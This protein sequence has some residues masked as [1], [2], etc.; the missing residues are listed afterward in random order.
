MTNAF[1]IIIILFCL[2]L[3]ACYP[4]SPFA[5]CYV[6]PFNKNEQKIIDSLNKLH[7]YGN[8]CNIS[9]IHLINI[10]NN[11]TCEISE[12]IY[13]L[14]YYITDSILFQ[15]T[16][17]LNT[18]SENLIKNIYFNAMDDT[19]KAIVER[20]EVTIK[21]LYN[22]EINDYCTYIKK[23]D[24]IDYYGEGCFYLM[25]NIIRFE[26]PKNEKLK[27]YHGDCFY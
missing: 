11:E 27:L 25:G 17:S 3:T 23:K 21:C 6:A 4:P 13:A 5:D 24:L 22:R 8:T 7:I 14:N 15:N 9:R 1:K 2:Q 19:L 20:V 26:V 18:L 16:D 10:L 12:P